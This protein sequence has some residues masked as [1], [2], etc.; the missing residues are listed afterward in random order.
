MPKLDENAAIELGAD[1][2]G[3][4]IIFVVAATTITLEYIRQSRNSARA[5][6]AEEERWKNVESQIDALIQVINKQNEAIVILGNTLPSKS[7]EEKESK[8]ILL[9]AIEDAKSKMI[10]KPLESP[11][12]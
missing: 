9:K 11:E 7:R 12:S 5:A 8:S 6:A 1:L 10:P 2:L 4:T 3:E